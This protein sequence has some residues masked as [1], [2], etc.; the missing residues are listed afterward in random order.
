MLRF[1][2]ARFHKRDTAHQ[3]LLYQAYIFSTMSTFA[4]DHG[5]L[6]VC[7]YR[8]HLNELI[9]LTRSIFFAINTYLR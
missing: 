3:S 2:P 6:V 4:C 5:V 7:K 9:L 8:H 1:P